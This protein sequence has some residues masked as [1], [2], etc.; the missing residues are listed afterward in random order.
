MV[1]Q[2]ASESLQVLR[3]ENTDLTGVPVSFFHFTSLRHLSLKRLRIFIE[4]NFPPSCTSV[5][6]D[7]YTVEYAFFD[8]GHAMPGPPPENVATSLEVLRHRPWLHVSLRHAYWFAG[9]FTRV[10]KGLKALDVSW[11]P[12]VSDLTMH[13]VPGLEVLDIGRTRITIYGLLAQKQL[14]HLCLSIRRSAV[15]IC[16]LVTCSQDPITEE[17]LLLYIATTPSLRTVGLWDLSPYEASA[18]LAKLRMYLCGL[19]GLPAPAGRA[20]RVVLFPGYATYPIIRKLEADPALYA[21]YFNRPPL[22]FFQIQ[23][24]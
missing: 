17:Q 4:V 18:F 5:H 9:G 3:I 7:D 6:M 22:H 23:R 2:C 20:V 1:L 19:P 24:D 16:G 21:G 11:N 8:Q 12:S 14:Q 13:N 15:D 10:W